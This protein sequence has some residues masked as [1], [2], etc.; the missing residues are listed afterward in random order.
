MSDYITAANLEL[1]VEQNEKIKDSIKKK[2]LLLMEQ[3]NLR[4]GIKSE[5]KLAFKIL[6]QHGLIQLP[7][8]NTYWSGA[9]YY[10]G[11][12]KI[13]VINTALP[14]MNQ[15]FTAWHEVYH[16]IYGE[17]ERMNIYQ[18][19]SDLTLA[20]RKAD[21]F[22]AKALMGNVY[23]YYV[24]LNG[25]DFMDKIAQCMDMY[26]VPYKAI[27]IQLYEDAKS[28]DNLRLMKEIKENFDRKD[29][30]WVVCFRRLGLDEELV[31]P[32]NVVNISYL[33]GKIKRRKDEEAE[34]SI[35]ELNERYFMSLKERI[36]KIMKE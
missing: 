22:A 28:A 1:I 14:R 17:D 20:E 27:L 26:Q 36:N 29:Q 19:S 5:E 30:D 18:I 33:E 2:L 15:F 6:K 11:D 16:L 21:Y 31:T 4:D 8:E 34:V 23:S 10:R 7:I 9:I 25:D 24:E 12:K 13:P 32:S 3:Y 35:H